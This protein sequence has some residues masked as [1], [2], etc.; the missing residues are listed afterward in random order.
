MTS[1]VSP[2][3]E[4]EVYIDAAP[5]TVEQALAE[6]RWHAALSVTP[7]GAGT[8]VRIVASADPAAIA[9]ALETT[10]LE[11]VCAVKRRLEP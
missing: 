10:M 3:I 5:M 6:C 2:S 11:A 4:R 7:E 1:N 9:G 8:R